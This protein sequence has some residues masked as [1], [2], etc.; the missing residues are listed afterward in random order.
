MGTPKGML[1]FDTHT[2]LLVQIEFLNKNLDEG[3]LGRVNV[4]QVQALMCYLCGGEHA[5]ERCS[6]EGTSEEVQFANF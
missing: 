3:S 5:N 1:P 2:A 4:S 6:F